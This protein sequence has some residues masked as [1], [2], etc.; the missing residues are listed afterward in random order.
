LGITI[1]NIPLD[2]PQ[3]PALILPLLRVRSRFYDNDNNVVA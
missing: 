1:Y 2:D 3:N